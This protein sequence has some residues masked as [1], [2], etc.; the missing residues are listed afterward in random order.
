MT[1]TFNNLVKSFNGRI[2]FE[3]I[4]G[5]INDG[6]RIGIIGINGVGKTTLVKILTGKEEVDEGKISYSHDRLTFGYLTQFAEFSEKTT[7]YEELFKSG[8]ED[9]NSSCNVDKYIRRVRKILLDMGFTEKTMNKETCKLS[10]GEK[11]K[12]SICKVILEDPDVLFLD[13]PTNHLDM[14]SIKCL[15]EF[16]NSIKKTIVVISHDREFLDNTVNKIFEMNKNEIREYSGNYSKY[17]LQKEN[18]RKNQQREYDKQEREI[19]HLKEVIN[20]RKTW[21]ASAH[22]AAGQNDF[23]RSKA[24]KHAKVMKAKERQLERLENNKVKRPSVDILAAFDCI[25]KVKQED[26]RLPEYII[27]VNNINKSFGN[28]V[29]LKNASFNIKIGDKAALMGGNGIGKTTLIKMLLGKECIDSGEVYINPSLKIAYFSQ[30]LEEL[31]YSNS[32]LDEML[33]TGASVQAARL[34]LG[35]LLFRGEDVFKKIEVLSMG[36]KCRAAFG[37]LILSGADMLILDEPTNYMDIISREKIEEV[38]EKY[39]GTILFV[40][41]D[42]YFIKRTSNR[43]LE[44]ENSGVSSYEGNYEYY[45]KQKEELRN[46]KNKIN[47]VNIRDEIRRLECEIAFISGK[48]DD[49]KIS[50]EEREELN[51]RFLQTAKQI[52][53]FKRIIS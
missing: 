10:G 40:S 15:E 50:Y 6:D 52:N 49:S 3:N 21:Y 9:I 4:S 42:R 31:N 38:I 18:E 29:L 47:Y 2:I 14:E 33:T 45:L 43:I 1:I 28:R 27:K 26:R 36:E 12:L 7:V 41:H 30:E 13:E 53:E 25:N 24:K 34:L 35:C 17:K 8:I 19:R 48:L 23:L 20:D 16:L 44:I 39:E 22:R 46:Q 5:K 32:I 11:T 51:N 37:K